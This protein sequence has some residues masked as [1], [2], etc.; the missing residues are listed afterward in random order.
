MAFLGNPGPARIEG[1]CSG[2]WGTFCTTNG[3]PYSTGNRQTGA[4]RAKSD[5]SAGD[6]GAIC[7]MRGRQSRRG[8]NTTSEI[9]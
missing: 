4:G 5:D 3:M 8:S 7:T 6:L 1:V 2:F 9:S